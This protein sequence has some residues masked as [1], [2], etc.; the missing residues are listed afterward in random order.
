MRP[1]TVLYMRELDGS[2]FSRP[3]TR[4]CLCGFQG[5]EKNPFLRG[6]EEEVKILHLICIKCLGSVWKG[7]RVGAVGD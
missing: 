1:S 5:A 7:R 3:D 2:L 6:S 4:V